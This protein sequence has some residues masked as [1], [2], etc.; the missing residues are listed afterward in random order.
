MLLGLNLTAPLTNKGEEMLQGFDCLLE[1][2]L[3]FH[4]PHEKHFNKHSQHNKVLWVPNTDLIPK[5]DLLL[6]QDYQQCPELTVGQS[7][8]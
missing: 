2:Q 7:L 1:I 8:I 5:V 4:H 3:Q 6:L